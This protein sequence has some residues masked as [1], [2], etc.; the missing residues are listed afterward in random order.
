MK[1]MLQDCTMIVE[2]PRCIWVEQLPSSENGI[3]ASNSKC[4][5]V[6]GTYP[7]LDRAKEVLKEVFECQRNGRYN[8]LCRRNRNAPL[9][10]PVPTGQVT[11]QLSKY[12][13]CG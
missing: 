5:P 12:R 1:I 6:L 3:I 8:F 7:T 11:R 4:A 2:Q 13:V 10:L 9:V